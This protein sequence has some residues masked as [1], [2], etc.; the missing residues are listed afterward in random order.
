MTARGANLEAATVA[1]ERKVKELGIATL[2]VDPVSIAKDHGITVQG[3]SLD[4]IS[5]VL[6]FSKNNVGILYATNVAGG[7][8]Q[9]FCVAHELGHY[10]LPGHPEAL[11]EK[12]SVHKSRAGFRDQSR[13]ELEADHFAAGLLMPRLLFRAELARSGDG[14][15]AVLKMAARCETSLTATAIRYAQCAEEPV[16]VIVSSDGLVD[17]CFLSEELAE[18]SDIAWLHK[19][20][21]IP[22]DSL[23][24]ACHQHPSRVAGGARPETTSDL[25]IWLESPHAVDVV[26]EVMSLGGSKTLT[27]LRNMA[28][29]EAEDEAELEES[30]TP[31]FSR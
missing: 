25:R 19:R 17:Y 20:D 12:E 23:T 2:P 22:E 4:G 6:T 11:F 7:G 13:F 1:A 29:E 24:L 21:P 8:F 15:A 10:F 27:V 30:W 14:L 9:H 31:R 3:A 26:E 18:R 16:A 28:F 5:G